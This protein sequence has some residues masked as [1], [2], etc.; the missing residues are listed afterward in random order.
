[1]GWWA[2]RRV[3][4]EENARRQEEWAAARVRSAELAREREDRQRAQI[5]EKARQRD[6]WYEYQRRVGVLAKEMGRPYGTIDATLRQGRVV[7]PS[8]YDWLFSRLDQLEQ[9]RN[10]DGL[11]LL[12]Q[13]WKDAE[14]AVAR[15]MRLN[16]YPD[17]RTTGA[18]VDGGI[19]VTSSKAVAQVKWHTT[20]VGRPV[21]QQLRG[22][23]GR[24][25]AFVAARAMTG[26]SF[27]SG[28]YAWAKNNG[29]RLLTVDELGEV[30]EV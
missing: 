15:W 7:P 12:M 22:A 19:D 26:G 23:A 2:E 14:A 24:K 13:T 16:G 21:I 28:A 1:M 9:N 25:A 10:L 5:K 27:S 30:R 6:Q 3:R 4:A 29:V 18:G 8:Q 20:K 17:A 11:P